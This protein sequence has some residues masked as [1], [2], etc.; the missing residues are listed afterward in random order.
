MA[1]TG[2]TRRHPKAIASRQAVDCG[3]PYSSM[4]TGCQSCAVSSRVRPRNHLPEESRGVDD[5]AAH[6]H[7]EAP[8]CR[9]HRT[10]RDGLPGSLSIVIQECDDG[11]WI[12]DFDDQLVIVL[13]LKINHH[14]T[15]GV[16]HIPE[17][18]SAIVVERASRQ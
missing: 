17:H 16:M 8:G 18:P 6:D 5:G 15:V 9:S 7:L 13:M 12:L 10:I 14:G 4:P 11:I 1:G 3:A 2:K